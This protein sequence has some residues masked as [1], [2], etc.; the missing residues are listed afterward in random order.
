MRRL[1][2]RREI[3]DLRIASAINSLKQ[4][5]IDALRMSSLSDVGES[6]ASRLLDEKSRELSEYLEDLAN[7]QRE[8]EELG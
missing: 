5:E 7:A 8:I 1:E 4:L 3:T 6:A 2:E